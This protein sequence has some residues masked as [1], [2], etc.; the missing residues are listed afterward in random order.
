MRWSW[1]KKIVGRL[2]PVVQQRVAVEL[3]DDLV[4]E[5]LEQ[6]L[7]ELRD[8]RAGIR[9][10]GETG[11]QRQPLRH[12]VEA[13]REVVETGWIPHVPIVRAALARPA[14]AGT[15]TANTCDLRAACGANTMLR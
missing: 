15:P 1:S 3:G 4:V 8:G 6:V 11:D 5:G 10:S 7:A 14:A 2:R 13:R 9:E 12:L